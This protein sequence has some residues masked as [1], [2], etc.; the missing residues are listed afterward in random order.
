MWQ[1]DYIQCKRERER[2]YSHTMCNVIMAD[3]E[4][5]TDSQTDRDSEKDRVTELEKV[6]FAKTQ[7]ERERERERGSLIVL[8][9]YNINVDAIDNAGAN[10]CRIDVYSTL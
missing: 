1:Y 4:G 9:S 5:Q 10:G 8:S 6:H 3:R 7:R 2:L